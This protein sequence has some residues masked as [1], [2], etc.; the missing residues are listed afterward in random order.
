MAV[1][2]KPPK[3]WNGCND[4]VAARKRLALPHAEGAKNVWQG[5]RD[6]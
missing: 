5:R 6:P 3:E 2:I 4:D 1:G